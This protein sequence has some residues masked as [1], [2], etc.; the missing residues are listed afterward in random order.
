MNAIVMVANGRA[1]MKAIVLSIK[2]RKILKALIVTDPLA[3]TRKDEAIEWLTY[4]SNDANPF[5]VFD[6]REKELIIEALINTALA[7]RKEENFGKAEL[8]GRF[9]AMARQARAA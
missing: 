5:E 4:G 1:G 8:A 7:Y 6:Q 2:R 3:S 9:E